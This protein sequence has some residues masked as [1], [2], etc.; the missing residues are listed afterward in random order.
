MEYNYIEIEGKL[1]KVGIYSL[2]WLNANSDFP[3][4]QKKVFDKFGLKLNQTFQNIDH[5]QWLTIISRYE[6][7][8]YLIFFDMD[9]I[10][11]R[12]DFLEIVIARM[13]RKN[14]ILGIE[15]KANHIPNS[16][17]YAGPACFVIS[18]STYLELGQPSYSHTHR[19]DV[20]EEL[21][22]LSREKGIEVDLFKFKSCLNPKWPYGD[23]RYFGIGTTYEDLVFHNFE[24]RANAQ[25]N[26][27]V[28]KCKEVIGEA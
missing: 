25:V 26:F 22:I 19:G 23:G 20:G 16:S 21:S 1:L 14:K 8:D 9:A 5:A 2:A 4:Y 6:D 27:F 28:N 13:Y 15:Q 3:L 12:K 24:S 17:I 18:K 11:L 7:V 10:P